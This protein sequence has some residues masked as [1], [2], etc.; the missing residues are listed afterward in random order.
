MEAGEAGRRLGPGEC[1][2]AGEGEA[3]RAVGDSSLVGSLV[4]TLAALVEGS[5]LGSWTWPGADSVGANCPGIDPLCSDL[6]GI[7]PLGADLHGIGPPG[8]DLHSIGPPGSD[9]HGIDPLDSDPPV[10]PPGYSARTSPCGSPAA[11]GCDCGC[12]KTS[13]SVSEATAPSL[14]SSPFPWSS[15]RCLVPRFPSYHT[16]APGSCATF[17]LIPQILN[18]G[19]SPA[20]RPAFAC[21][22]ARLRV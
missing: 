12:W 22:C 11:T 2:G 8:S 7:D 10:W 21:T 3:G 5:L 20:K 19:Q 15:P 6:H 9:L 14:F 17:D 4:G 16:S 1:E 18:L 13:G